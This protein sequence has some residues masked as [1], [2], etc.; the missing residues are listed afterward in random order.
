MSG[1]ALQIYTYNGSDAQKWTLASARTVRQQLD[2]LAAS[3]RGLV[4]EGKEYAI[5]SLSERQVFDIVS[6]SANSGANL[7]VYA[8]NATPA[9][10][11]TFTYDK[12]GYVTI[13]NVGSGKVL[14]VSGGNKKAGANVQQYVPNG[15]WAQKWILVNCGDGSV[16]ICSALKI[17][18]VLDLAGGATS[19]GANVQVYDDNG[20]N[21]Q[22]FRLYTAGDVSKGQTIDSQSAV[23]TAPDGRVF[24]VTS[25]S[26]DSGASIQLY[27]P[28]GTIAQGFG[29]EYDAAKGLYAIK[30]AKS[31][32]YLFAQDGDI[33]P[34]AAVKQGSASPSLSNYCW[35]I[36]DAGS[37]SYRIV[38]AGS[39]RALG[40]NASG[41]LVTV[42][43]G[44]PRELSVAFTP[45]GFK[46]LRSE[47]DA[48]AKAH[49][50]DLA[51]G[52]Y[53]VSSSK[54]Y[55]FVLDVTGGSKGN[56]A[57]IQLYRSN[58]SN[59][60]R[61]VVSHDDKGYV[62]FT[63]AGSNKVIDVAGGNAS[64]GTNIAQYASN[65]TYAQKWI[66]AKQSNGTYLIESALRPGL[67]LG[68]RGSGASN[69]VNVELS[70]NEGASQFALLGTSLSVAK[71]DDI[72]PKGY[73]TLSPACSSTGKVIDVAG[74]SSSNGANVQL[75]S[76]NG[77]LAQL[78]SFEYYDGYY[79]IRNAK[80][81]KAFDVDSGNLIPGTN[82][83]QW[84]CD[85]DN[86]NRLFAA[87]DNGDGTYSFVNKSTGLALDIAGAS[88]SAQ[89]N[90]DAYLPNGTA[91]QKFSL[92]R[93]SEFLDEGAYSFESD[94]SSKVL[95]VSGGSMG[96]GAAVQ[97]YAS[98]GTLAQKWYVSKVAGLDNE[99]EIKCIGSG[100]V[101][102]L[103]DGGQLVQLT[104][105]G[106]DSQ[107]WQS[108][109]S[110]GKIA[111]QNA[112]TGQY[113]CASGSSASLGMVDSPELPGVRFKVRSV[114][115]SF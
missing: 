96:D 109:L 105:S 24:D 94:T 82:V 55:S 102:S 18:F 4:K 70:S 108:T 58:M 23:V 34:G 113:L 68:S 30:S 5:G 53:L 89:A 88:D 84:A 59:A 12:N 37:G 98:N 115:G 101:L 91:A 2:D 80:S 112:A 83:Q 79:V 64:A 29:F 95:D 54:N 36:E 74:G 46:C 51:D 69:G 85:S 26:M 87:I 19:N 44:D 49:V 9:Q 107:R 32:R 13:T 72:L 66:A 10:R 45:S 21:A 1:S 67:Y 35:A 97:L 16:K 114:G 3:G 65:G 57:N 11:W 52:E 63:N 60:Q 110:G 92:H 56:S 73:F 31:Y 38:N 90:L 77:T 7:Q 100:K 76:S 47:Q 40:A 86:A 27:S 17:D 14:D 41:K 43:R 39:G 71:C 99:Y 81:Q 28:N 78:F 61:W 50:S 111:L 33:V 25:G 106:A 42:S 103:T 20:T 6:G 93:V 104:S 22:R 48:E 62:T 75:Y 8:S 15:S